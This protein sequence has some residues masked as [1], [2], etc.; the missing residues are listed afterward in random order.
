[1]G[2]LGTVGLTVIHNDEARTLTMST[3]WGVVGTAPGSATMAW[4]VNGG[5]SSHAIAGNGHWERLLAVQ[6]GDRVTLVVKPAKDV[7]SSCLIQGKDLLRSG[8]DLCHV[9]FVP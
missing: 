5:K 3:A 7:P 4:T 9:E 6:R 1:M 8:T 2:V